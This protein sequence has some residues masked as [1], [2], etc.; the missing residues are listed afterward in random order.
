MASS[1]SPSD[2]SSD[3]AFAFTNAGGIRATIDAGPVTRG[4]VLA[5]L[6][7]VGG[8]AVVIVSGPLYRRLSA[9][10]STD[11]CTALLDRYVE[12]VVRA[13]EPDIP[14]GELA[15]RKARARDISASDAMFARCTTALTQ[16]EAECALR[17]GNADEFERCLP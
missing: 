10:P 4:E 16:R 11:T 3:A 12:H 1:L 13:A 7:I 14:A 6:A 2:F 8:L 5:T 9:H 15:T 17:A